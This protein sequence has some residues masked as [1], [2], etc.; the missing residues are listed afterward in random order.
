MERNEKVK[1]EQK[2]EQFDMVAFE[3]GMFV[4]CF[5][6]WFKCKKDTR[7]KKGHCNTCGGWKWQ[8]GCYVN[9]LSGVL[10]YELELFSREKIML[11]VR[12]SFDGGKVV[13]SDP[14]AALDEVASGRLVPT[15]FLTHLACLSLTH[16]GAIWAMIFTY[17]NLGC[18]GARRL[19][20]VV[21]LYCW[22][23]QTPCTEVLKRA[24]LH[25]QPFG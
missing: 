20:H 10:G 16:H 25:V 7:T 22:R 18:V 17:L 24:Q 6:F 2:R 11:Y 21:F 23:W 3:A 12:T 9:A 13:F 19:S 5:G 4:I 1:G 8:L 14:E 15:Q